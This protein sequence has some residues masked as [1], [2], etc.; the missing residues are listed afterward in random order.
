MLNQDLLIDEVAA[1]KRE[2]RKEFDKA[3]YDLLAL[4]WPYRE[5]AFSFADSTIYNSAI[6]IC[7]D[8]SDECA[9]KA[10]DRIKRIVEDYV[11]EYNEDD[12]WAT[13]YDDDAIARYDMAGTHLLDL[14][15]VWIGVAATNNWTQGYT[16]IM[17]SRYLHNPFLCPEWKQI[18]LDTL[19]WGRGYAKDIAEQIAVIG[20]D[21]IVAGARTAEQVDETTKG[22][23]Y[24][25]RRRGSYYD[26]DV[27]QE[28]VGI[29]IPIDVPFEIPHARCCCFPEYHYEEI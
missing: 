9:L 14:L 10:K 1:Y 25:I 7:L 29:P 11:D 13:V 12:I 18:P 15:G 6:S 19:A 24:Y 21:I 2:S 8:L 3:V 23:T 28:L 17:F 27:C 5:E 4:A 16:R 20:Q 26:C 22:A